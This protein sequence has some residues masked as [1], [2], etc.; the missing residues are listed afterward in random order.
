[1]RSPL[2]I[3]GNYT[4]RLYGLNTPADPRRDGSR[5]FRD[6][7]L[8]RSAG[9]RHGYELGDRMTGAS[10]HYVW[11]E[12]HFSFEV[13]LFIKEGIRSEH[14]T[15]DI[16][17]RR[18]DVSFGGNRVFGDEFVHTVACK[19]GAAWTLTDAA[20][21]F[22]AMDIGQLQALYEAIPL[23][24]PTVPPSTVAGTHGCPSQVLDLSTDTNVEKQKVPNSYAH[25]GLLSLAPEE[26]ED[27]K[28][29][30]DRP[31]LH[32]ILQKGRNWTEMWGSPFKFI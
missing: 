24:V 6:H 20:C 2:S 30:L 11:R 21:R 7:T 18:M 27:V 14:V 10:K 22:P 5:G 29:P 23:S 4:S 3:L 17:S 31:A 15:W 28:L 25:P 19:D 9:I 13:V 26:V 1:M 32:I 16:N 8:N 12:T